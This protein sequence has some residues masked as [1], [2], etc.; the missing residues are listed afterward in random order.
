MKKTLASII[1]A[2][3]LAFSSGCA[4]PRIPEARYEPPL[5]PAPAVE[6]ILQRPVAVAEEKPEIKESWDERQLR[7][8]YNYMTNYFSRSKNRIDDIFVKDIPEKPELVLDPSFLFIESRELSESYE[9]LLRKIRD[10][11]KK[12]TRETI[13]KLLK[14]GNGSCGCF[15]ASPTGVSGYILGAPT[16][17]QYSLELVIDKGKDVTDGDAGEIFYMGKVNTTNTIAKFHLPILIPIEH[18]GESFEAMV[19]AADSKG[20]QMQSEPFRAYLRGAC[21]LTDEYSP[22]KLQKLLV[23]KE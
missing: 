14:V 12:M 22:D 19:R 1:A 5:S 8:T 4:S 21:R 7:E 20:N 2:F 11:G 10:S 9:E 23:D 6:S 15:I 16:N 17:E 13:S 3:A 18:C